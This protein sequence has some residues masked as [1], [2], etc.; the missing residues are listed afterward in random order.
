MEVA[1]TDFAE[2]QCAAVAQARRIG[3][4]LMSGVRLRDARGAAAG[5][6][7]DAVVRAQRRR[8][9]AELGRQRFVECQ[10]PRRGDRSALPGYGEPLQLADE[11]IV[12]GE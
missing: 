3:P 10:Q 6:E 2:Q 12:E 8:V 11:R 4:E 7:R 9:R 1:A 5:Q